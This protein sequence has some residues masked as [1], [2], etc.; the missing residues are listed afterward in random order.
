VAPRFR[1]GYKQGPSSNGIGN[2]EIPSLPPQDELSLRPPP[3]SMVKMFPQ[4]AKPGNLFGPAYVEHGRSSP[5]K[6][7]PARNVIP[8][9][10]AILAKAAK[11][12]IEKTQT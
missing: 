3:N 12:T 7:A 8:P 9:K 11:T 2:P 1:K 6:M 10:E 5:P 4:A